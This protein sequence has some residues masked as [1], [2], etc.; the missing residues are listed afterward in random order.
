MRLK[1]TEP[2]I[3]LIGGG[4]GSSVVLQGLKGHPV[5]L[6][7]IVTMFDSGGS[8]GLLREEFGYPP[9]GDLRQCLLALS[10]ETEHDAVSVDPG[11]AEHAA[12]VHGT[13]AAHG[14][15][16]KLDKTLAGTHGVLVVLDGGTRVS[17]RDQVHAFAAPASALLVRVIEHE[18]AGKLVRL[19]VHLGAE[20][21]HDR[22]RLDQQHRTSILDNLVVRLLR[23]SQ[24]HGVFHA[25][26][27]TLLDA[28]PQAQRTWVRFHEVANARGGGFRQCHGFGHHVQ[29]RHIV[30]P[31]NNVSAHIV[32]TPHDCE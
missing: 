26:A 31:G 12:H 24:G 27:A 15:L 14:V 21:I 13:E 30:L 25:G 19:V 22:S 11:A 18:L 32:Q 20:E 6:T 3:V 4:S 2:K 10:D 1:T 9:L 28:D 8:S 5:D 29:C 7:A 16:E 17:R 23:L